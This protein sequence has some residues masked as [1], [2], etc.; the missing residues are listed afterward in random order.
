MFRYHKILLLFIGDIVTFI[1]VGGIVK[2]Q[3]R[4]H[5]QANNSDTKMQQ[6]VSDGVDG[7][8]TMGEHWA[9]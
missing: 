2:I 8:L 3:N 5:Y 6:Y 1:G 4:A 7:A 9:L